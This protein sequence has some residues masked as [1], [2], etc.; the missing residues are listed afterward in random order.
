MSI[1]IFKFD[2]ALLQWFESY[3]SNRS[4]H[5]VIGS[6]RSG[7]ITPSSGVPQGSILGPF[8]F[9]LFVND[10]LSTLSNTLAFADDLKLLKK[11]VSS[12]DCYIFQLEIDRLQEWCEANKLGLNVKKCAIMSIKPQSMMVLYNSLVRSRLEYCAAIWSPIYEKH[13]ARESTKEIHTHVFLQ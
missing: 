13:N 1:L 7:R 8:L 4:Q 6:G 12:G 3:L 9:I 5:V 10:L 2:K 11:I